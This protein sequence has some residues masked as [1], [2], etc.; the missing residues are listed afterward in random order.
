MPQH[1]NHI[2][3]YFLHRRHR[4]YKN[5]RHECGVSTGGRDVRYLLKQSYHQEEYVRPSSEL[6]EQ[7]QRHETKDT[8][9]GQQMRSGSPSQT[10]T[11]LPVFCSGDAVVDEFRHRRLCPVDEYHAIVGDRCCALAFC[12]TV[13]GRRSSSIFFI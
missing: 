10:N 6:L 2:F 11:C 9:N 13:H 1:T 7:E 8:G 3:N 5:Q 4:Q 12:L